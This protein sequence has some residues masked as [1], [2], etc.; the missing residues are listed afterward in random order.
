MR[1]GPR[2]AGLSRWL[3]VCFLTLSSCLSAGAHLERNGA[4]LALSCRLS[5]ADVCD[6]K[7]PTAGDLY[8]AVCA[9]ALGPQHEACSGISV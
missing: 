2:C 4:A 5:V 6:N 9:V 8:S 1:R 7:A 3:P